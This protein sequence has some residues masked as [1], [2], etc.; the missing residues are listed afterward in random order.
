VRTSWA[1]EEIKEVK[2]DRFPLTWQDQAIL[3]LES[4]SDPWNIQLEVAAPAAI[5]VPRLERAL[6]AACQRHPIARSRLV[7]GS[8]LSPRNH[9]QPEDLAGVSVPVRECPTAAG[10]DALRTELYSAA[11]NLEAAPPFRVVVAR[12]PGAGD[13]MLF[14][15]AHPAVDGIGL[16]RLL[17][18]VCRAYQ[19]QD[20]PPDP[21]PL[22]EARALRRVLR[23]RSCKEFGA[24]ALE[25]L[26]K[27]RGA[28]NAPA[29][30]ATES[31]DRRDAAGFVHRTL[32][33]EQTATVSK[34][35][36][37]GTTV[38]D[39]ILAA[40]S[41]ALHRW[42]QDHGTAADKIQLF[43]PVSVRPTE[44]ATEIVSNLFSYV[45]VATL[46]DQRD[47][48][49]STAL[50]VS[51]QTSPF[52]RTA[53]AGGTQDLLRLI[54]PL[55]VGVKR[56]MPHLLTLTGNRFVDSAVVSNLGRPASLPSF[57]QEHPEEIYFTP[58]YWSA[59]AISIGAITSGD[60]L[61]IGL[62]HRLS[63]LDADAG[64]RFA[65]LLIQQLT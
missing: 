63:V 12:R 33:P 14:N 29:R 64:R 62:R 22:T 20:D 27:L 34:N 35:R 13:L 23:P 51:S 57:D 44:W 1:D 53:R 11:L 50:A 56:N 10:V 54:S 6:L 36:P 39:L 65:E 32:T 46:A 8:A 19:G 3:D 59:A 7:P 61:H 49:A 40:A 9:W 15:A 18:S 60:S 30:V 31:G 24:R 41:L 45:S 26:R 38:N 5:D 16:L 25:G 52:R 2:V 21:V 55:P 48:L 17:S 43:M 4:A 37:E 42:N 28:V 58:P 47:D